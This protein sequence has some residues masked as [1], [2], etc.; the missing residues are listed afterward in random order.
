[1]LLGYTKDDR[2]EIVPLRILGERVKLVEAIRFLPARQH[3][4]IPEIS[5]RP[6]GV[7]LSTERFS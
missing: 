2:N 1:M 6:I 5:Y 7:R 3:Q 4:V